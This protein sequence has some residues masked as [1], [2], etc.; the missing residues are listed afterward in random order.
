MLVGL[1]KVFLQSC[2]GQ[3]KVKILAHQISLT[4]T[5]FLLIFVIFQAAVDTLDILLCTLYK[6]ILKVSGL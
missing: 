6:Y 1:S 3:S 5:H 4:K 2:I